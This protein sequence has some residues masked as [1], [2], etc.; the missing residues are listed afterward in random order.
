MLA[1]LINDE[2]R[3]SADKVPGLSQLPLLGR[4]FSNNDDTVNKT[5]IVLL[6]TPRVVRNIERPGARIEEF[7]SGTELEVGGAAA[8]ALPPG[9]RRRAAQPRAAAPVPAAAAG[10]PCRPAAGRRPAAEAAI[11]S[12]RLHAD[13]AADRGGDRGAARLGRRCRSP[14]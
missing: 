8:S 3:R 14:R 11:A 2:D 13:R 1:G 6:I 10:S 5:E 12:Q 9:C 4:L 7:I